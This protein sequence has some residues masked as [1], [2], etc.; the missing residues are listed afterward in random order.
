MSYYRQNETIKLTSRYGFRVWEKD[1]RRNNFNV[2]FTL[3]EQDMDWP[4]DHSYGLTKDDLYRMYVF[5]GGM[6]A[7]EYVDETGT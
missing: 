1:D 5:I 7:D 4:I 3:V 2:S 6:L